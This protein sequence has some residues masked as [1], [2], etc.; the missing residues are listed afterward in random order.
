MEDDDGEKKDFFKM[1]SFLTDLN[2]GD[3]QF[4]AAGQNHP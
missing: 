2:A 4:K 1:T 3:E